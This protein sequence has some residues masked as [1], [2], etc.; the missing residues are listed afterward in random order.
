LVYFK[1]NLTL[2]RRDWGNHC[3]SR[4]TK[5]CLWEHIRTQHLQRKKLDYLLLHYKARD[6]DDDDDDDDDHDGYYY[7]YCYELCLLRYNAMWPAESQPT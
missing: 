3:I 2:V 5:Y 7:N 1:V 4:D 6:S